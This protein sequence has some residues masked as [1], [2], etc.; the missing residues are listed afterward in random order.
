VYKVAVFEENAGNHSM[1]RAL[2]HAHAVNELERA[3]DLVPVVCC[4]NCLQPDRQND[5]GW[6]Q[7]LLFLNPERVW[8]QPP[9]FV[10]Q[11]LS[12]SYLPRVV[13]ADVTS[14]GNALDV[15]AKADEGGAVVQLQVVNLDAKP[16]AARLRLAGFRPAKPTAR[17]VELAGG[18]DGRNTA[19][20]PRRVAPRER[21]WRHGFNDGEAGYTFPPHSFTVIRFE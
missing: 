19:E 13:R 15:T 14:P 20:E 16:V 18:L 21:D 17:V 12:R 8:A 5:N 10:T 11:M 6:D 4:A 1:R 2:A 7:G 9:Y 3:G